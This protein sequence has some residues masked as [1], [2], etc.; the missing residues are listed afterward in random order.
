MITIQKKLFM[1]LLA[2]LSSYCD[3]SICYLY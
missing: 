2:L 1:Y 3:V